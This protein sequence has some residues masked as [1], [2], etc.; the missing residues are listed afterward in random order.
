[1]R[2]L[3]EMHVRGV[4]TNGWPRLYSRV[5]DIEYFIC[6]V[7]VSNEISGRVMAW[8]KVFRRIA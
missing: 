1:M 7:C 8:R 5:R 6:G 4:N 3:I 2:G